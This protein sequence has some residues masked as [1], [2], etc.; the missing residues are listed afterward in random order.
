MTRLN[1]ALILATMLFNYPVFSDENQITPQS[2]GE[3]NFISGGV[4]SDEQDAIK[5]VRGEYNLSLLFSAQGTGEYLSDAEVNI[6]DSSGNPVLDTV[7][8][9][10]ML[11]A[12]LKP[13]NYTV[14][15]EL[16]GKVSRKKVKIGKKGKS[17]LSFAWLTV[18]VCQPNT[19][20][21]KHYLIRPFNVRTVRAELV[22]AEQAFKQ[23]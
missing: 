16:E 14:T 10:P 20:A 8:K 1:Q 4:G 18:D 6:T 2:Q 23:A 19:K 5:A 22:E 21:G 11:L 17:A 9:G 3:A 12:K 13:G 15:A 7:A